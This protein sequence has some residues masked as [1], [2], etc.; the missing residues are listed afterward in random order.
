MLVYIDDII[1]TGNNPAAINEVVH[2]LSHSFP[3][4]D[5]GQL[6]YFL[7]I[8]I[9]H[10]GKDILLSQQKYIL[11]LLD[12][13]NLSKAHPMPTPIST[14]ANLALGDSPPLDDPVQYQRI[15]GAFQYVTLSRPDITYA[16]NKFC[17]FMHSPLLITGPLSS[18][19]FDI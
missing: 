10:Q 7:G 2:G 3:I 8:E 17:Q 19:F 5:M 1:L 9:T 18:E 12:R 16:I 6:S 14:N 13:V 15:V 4:Q 11:E